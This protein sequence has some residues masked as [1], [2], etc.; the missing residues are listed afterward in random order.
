M[1]LW[2][3]NAG[4]GL[5]WAARD[6]WRLADEAFVRV[7]GDPWWLSLLHF[8]P[9]YLL[10]VLPRYTLYLFVAPAVLALL[11]RGFTAWVLAASIGLWLVGLTDWR[12]PGIAWLEPGY[13]RFPIV[14]W[15]MPF[16]LGVV[17]GW[18]RER[19][20]RWWRRIEGWPLAAGLAV[21]VLIFQKLRVDHLAEG[22]PFLEPGPLWIGRPVIGPFRCLALAIT[23]A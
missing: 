3:A 1:Q 14:S 8:E 10:H 9:P 11:R 16:F 21:G 23:F 17:L 4:I 5:L 12:Q 15:Q 22:R 7:W 2:L 18:H 6:A 13:V 19:V 20:A